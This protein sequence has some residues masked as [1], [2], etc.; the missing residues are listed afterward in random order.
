MMAIFTVMGAIKLAV[1]FFLLRPNKVSTRLLDKTD[2]D[3][4]HALPY[5]SSSDIVL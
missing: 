4:R 1:G 2:N 3:A 5:I